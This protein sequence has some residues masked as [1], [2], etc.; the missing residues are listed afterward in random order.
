MRFG[1][2][3]PLEVRD[4]QGNPVAVPAGRPARL[5]VGLL[6]RPARPVPTDW[7]VEMLWN[8]HAPR[9]YLANLQTHVSRLRR[10]LPDA[11]IERR[12]VER[13]GDAYQITI[14]PD[15]VDAER[16]ALHST[17][18]RAAGVGDQ[19]A[20]HFRAALALYR[21]APLAGA[22]G[23]FEPDLVRLA[24]LHLSSMEGLAEADLA[25]GRYHEVIVRLGP[26]VRRHPLREPLWDLLIRAFAHSGRAAEAVDAYHEVRT[27][28]RDEL[29]LDPGLRLRQTYEWILRG[30]QRQAE[31]ACRCK[32]TGSTVTA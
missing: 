28:L 3:G 7:L 21:G 5:L 31:T 32:E 18:G 12:D 17:A 23:P 30:T 22:A 15:C 10:L 16:F 19:A 13:C 24:E 14:D 1:I 9:S 4:E 11:P 2:L 8:G 20:A 27:V 6:L 25:A 26:L 29:G